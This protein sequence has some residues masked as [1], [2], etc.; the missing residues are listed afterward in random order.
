MTIEPSVLKRLTTLVG[1]TEEQCLI[2]IARADPQH[3]ILAEIGQMGMRYLDFARN[4][5]QIESHEH[6]SSVQK[7]WALSRLRSLPVEA[8]SPQRRR[9]SSRLREIM[10]EHV[11]SA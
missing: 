8:G 10:H 11:A 5:I 4:A 2:L 9:H 7:A 3:P 1:P 6:S